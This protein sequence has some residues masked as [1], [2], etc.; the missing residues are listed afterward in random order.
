MDD[1][2]LP[3]NQPTVFPE[4]LQTEHLGVDPKTFIGMTPDEAEAAAR[5]AGIGQIRMLE[6][7]DGRKVGAMDM[8][9]S[10]NRL[11]LEYENGQIVRAHFG[12]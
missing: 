8:M 2:S 12:P 10:P 4:M 5:N 1:D 7:V 9:L 6:C 11:N 3:G